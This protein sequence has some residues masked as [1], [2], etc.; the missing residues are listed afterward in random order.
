MR[1]HARGVRLDCVRRHRAAV[2]A[3][4]RRRGTGRAAERGLTNLCQ[5][6]SAHMQCV[7]LV[8]LLQLS[9]AAFAS[10]C[11]CCCCC[12][13]CG[14]GG[15]S[16]AA[17]SR[18]RRTQSGAGAVRGRCVLSYSSVSATYLRARKNG[19]D[20]THG[21]EALSARLAQR[22]SAAARRGC[23]L[24]LVVLALGVCR[25]PAA[26]RRREARASGVCRQRLR[27]C[28]DEQDARTQGATAAAAHARRA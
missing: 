8:H 7:F 10:A 12:C 3:A 13:G 25:P 28:R 18:S 21:H 17:L 15:C 5:V 22:G 1:S 24:V 20:N 27:P 16:P 4:S 2:G 14:G 26:A 6:A 9:L 23:A 11:C 19:R